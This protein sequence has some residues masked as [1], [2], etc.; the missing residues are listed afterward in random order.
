MAGICD[1]VNQAHLP[2]HRVQNFIMDA[3]TSPLYE[4]ET[5]VYKT[6]MSFN[7]HVS[8]QNDAWAAL[9]AV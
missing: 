8:V 1:L 3:G 6:D 4:P 5:G 9:P 7:L 2:Y